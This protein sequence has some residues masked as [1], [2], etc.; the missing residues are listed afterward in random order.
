MSPVI[1]S[2][3]VNQIVGGQMADRPSRASAAPGPSFD[4]DTNPRKPRGIAMS[5]VMAVMSVAAVFVALDGGLQAL[6]HFLPAHSGNSF[7]LYAVV[8]SR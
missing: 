5:F 6:A 1:I 8:S 7:P 3:V 4:A 2:H